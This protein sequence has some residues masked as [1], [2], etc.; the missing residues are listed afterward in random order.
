M[1]DGDKA[2]DI[3]IA[4]YPDGSQKE[5]EIKD[6]L[7]DEIEYPARHNSNLNN[8]WVPRF[9]ELIKNQQKNGMYDATCS[10]KYCT[11]AKQMSEDQVKQAIAAAEAVCNQ[12]EFKGVRFTHQKKED[13]WNRG[14]NL[15]IEFEW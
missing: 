5:S 13:R 3:D 12:S 10:P 1:E 7:P 14:Y 4:I 2:I 15:T 6:A 8:P 9:Q 11:D